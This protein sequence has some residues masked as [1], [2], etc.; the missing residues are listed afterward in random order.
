MITQPKVLIQISGRMIMFEPEN[1]LPDNFIKAKDGCNTRFLNTGGFPEYCLNK[2]TVREATND[3]QMEYFAL[4]DR[5]VHYMNYDKKE[6]Y[7][8]LIFINKL[9]YET[10]IV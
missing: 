8:F 9:K 1:D 10:E 6:S 2:E 7:N 5:S 3:E 4:K